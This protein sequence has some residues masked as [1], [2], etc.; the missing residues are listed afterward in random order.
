MW[1]S[2]LPFNH[3]FP[4]C[5]TLRS[6]EYLKT[7]NIMFFFFTIL[8]FPYFNNMKKSSDSQYY[9]TCLDLSFRFFHPNKV[10]LKSAIIWP[11]AKAS[12]DLQGMFVTLA[13]NSIFSLSV[14]TLSNQ[15][16]WLSTDATGLMECCTPATTSLFH[17][18]STVVLL[19]PRERWSETT[20]ERM[21]FFLCRLQSSVKFSVNIAEAFNA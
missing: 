3:S 20:H 21:S 1:K 10:P 6:C 16:L 9:Y 12:V 5:L 15:A 2:K 14:L 11:C 13:T 7:M 19:T 4:L 17:K 18:T 8:F